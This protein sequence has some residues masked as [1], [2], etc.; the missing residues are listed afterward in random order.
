MEGVSYPVDETETIV[1]CQVCGLVY[2]NPRLASESAVAVYSYEQEISYFADSCACRQR[3][4]DRLVHQLMRWYGQKPRKLLDV[5]CGDG[6]LIQVA[7]QL[8]IQSVGTEVSSALVSLVH[9][10]LG[11]DAIVPS[12]LSTLIPA[13]YDVITMLNVL[14]HLEE[15]GKML[16]ACASLLKPGGILLV[17]VPNLGGLPA[18]LAGARW[19]QLE[20]LEHFY[21]FTTQTLKMLMRRSGLEPIARFSLLTSGGWRDRLQQLFD[22]LGIYMDNGLG[23]VA[24]LANTSDCD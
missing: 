18:R 9:R 23:I 2:V 14:E 20:P 22:K 10:K 5:G 16:K 3:A 21:Y 19:H 17:H 8:G 7:R 6:T 11:S 13:D 15:P 12:D 4:Y 24:R 1:A